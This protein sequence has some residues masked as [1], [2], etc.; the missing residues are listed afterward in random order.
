MALRDLYSNFKKK[1][2]ITE[3]DLFPRN[4]LKA[5]TAPQRVGSKIVGGALTSLLESGA[6][7]GK[8]AVDYARQETRDP[9]KNL[10]QAFSRLVPQAKRGLLTGLQIQGAASPKTFGAL[11]GL[12]TTLDTAIGGKKAG[13]RSLS[14]QNI[15]RNLQTAGLISATNPL[16][17]KAV[18]G[19]GVTKFIPR[20]TIIGAGNVGE[21]VLLDKLRGEKSTPDRK[22]VV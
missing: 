12:S 5:I 11:Q 18:R 7:I 9:S 3:E 10:G 17:D 13:L 20:N 8:G 2:E 1:L 22:S 4:P 15:G 19:L 14:Q 21:D 6:G 16:A